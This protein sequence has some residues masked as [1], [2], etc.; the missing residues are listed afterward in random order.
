MPASQQTDVIEKI[1]H[2]LSRF[3]GEGRIT[4]QDFRRAIDLYTSLP[5][6]IQ[7]Q[8]WARLICLQPILKAIEEYIPV[9]SDRWVDLGCGHGLVSL[10]VASRRK[11]T[12]LGVEASPSR[13]AIAQRAAHGLQDVTF[14]HGN[15]A[16]M[17][18]PPSTTILLI[19]VLYL[20][21]DDIQQRIL[22]NCARA[23]THNGIL[24][25]KDNTTI[26][27][28]KYGYTNCEE[29][30][31]LL[32]RAYDTETIKSPNYRTPDSW[33][34]LI[35]QANLQIHAELFI[36]SPAPYPGIIYICQ[37]SSHVTL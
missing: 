36:K 14:Q 18:I 17:S 35:T 13:F 15:I 20:F 4:P 9:T 33:R 23:L 16:E 22:I 2:S 26:P 19:D 25:I 30:L 11:G 1:L 21:P 12:I 34:H 27:R 3:F 28:W 10:L 5:F 6:R 29:K 8:V 7:V 24:L 37:N 32:F 31:K